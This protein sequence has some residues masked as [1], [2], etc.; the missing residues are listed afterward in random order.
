MH[1]SG[2]I[3]P[4]FVLLFL[5][6]HEPVGAAENGATPDKSAFN[7]FNPVPQDLMRELAPDRPDQTESP[8]TVDAGHFQLEMDFANFTY[9]KTDSE[10]LRAWNIAPLNIKLGLVNNVDLQFVY[11][12]YLRV[13]TRSPATGAVTQS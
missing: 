2:L 10:T 13:R 8:Y 9:N 7:L 6:A 12:N 11:D 3:L 5:L 4:A 1:K